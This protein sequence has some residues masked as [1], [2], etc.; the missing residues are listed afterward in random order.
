MLGRTPTFKKYKLF[1]DRKGRSFIFRSSYEIAFVEQY[2]EPNGLT[3]DYEPKTFC[4]ENTSYTPDF[5]IDELQTFVEVKGWFPAANA[6]KIAL[7]MKLHKDV[8]LLLADKLVLKTNFSV[9]VSYPNL[10]KIYERFGNGTRKTRQQSLADEASK[11][12]KV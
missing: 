5:W 3:W 12:G 10:K 8:P 2:L 1:L 4:F 9:D 11:L 6:S 7:F